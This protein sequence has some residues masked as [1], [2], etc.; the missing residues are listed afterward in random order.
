MNSSG[1]IDMKKR[2]LFAILGAMILALST[3]ACG[4]S[5]TAPATETEKTDQAQENTESAAQAQQTDTEKAAQAQE[6]PESAAQAQ[7]ADTEKAAQTQ[8]EGDGSAAAG[9]TASAESADFAP[10]DSTLSEDGSVIEFPAVGVT[11]TLPESFKDTK[12]FLPNGGGEINPGDGVYCMY[13]N[14]IALDEDDYED[15][16]VK[17]R[18]NSENAE[19]YE[20]FFNPRVLGMFSI[21]AADGNRSAEDINEYMKKLN[22]ARGNTSARENPMEGAQLIGTVGEYNFY[23]LDQTQADVEIP[24][25]DSVPGAAYDL[26]GFNEEYK[27]LIEDVKNACPDLMTFSEPE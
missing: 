24:E 5:G 16:L 23:F 12:G 7:Q 14:Y 22:D 9:S 3:T 26:T 4:S 1:G 25:D 13:Y 20:N 18:T 17:Y 11:F 2:Q 8:Q 21:Y 15:L 19:K 6:D 27:K 10:E